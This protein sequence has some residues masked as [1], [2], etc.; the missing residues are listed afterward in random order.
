MLQVAAEYPILN[1]LVGDL[2]RLNVRG[3]FQR[4]GHLTN[5][6]QAIDVASS[7]ARVMLLIASGAM[8]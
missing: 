7:V 3:M 5:R 1:R 4:Q 2:I 6:R 8:R